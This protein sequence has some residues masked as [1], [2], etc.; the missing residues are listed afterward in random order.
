[1]GKEG[2]VW[3]QLYFK[4][5]LLSKLAFMWGGE[6]IDAYYIIKSN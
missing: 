4:G 3:G 1:M 2:V 6:F 5:R